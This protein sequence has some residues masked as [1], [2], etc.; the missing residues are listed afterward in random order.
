METLF[1]KR[2]CLIIATLLVGFSTHVF[3]FLDIEPKN[4][5]QKIALLLPSRGPHAE[6]A[7]TIRD[8]FLAAYYKNKDS[9]QSKVSMQVYDTGDG[10]QIDTAYERALAEGANLIVG[11][12]TKAE[13]SYIASLPSL[14][15]PVLAL[16]TIPRSNDLPSNLYQF[17][18]LPE[19]DVH[20]MV[21]QAR[22]Q[23]HGNALLIAPQNEWGK[24]MSG[25]IRYFWQ[26]RGGIIQEQVLLQ[27]SEDL[28]ASIKALLRADEKD[29]SRRNDIDVIFLVANPEL[30]RQVKSLL[31]ANFAEKLPIYATSS[32]YSGT[33]N[34]IKDQ[35]LDGVHFCD[36]PLLLDNP[37]DFKEVRQNII[38]LWPES[39]KK[40]PRYFAM[41]MDSYTIALQLSENRNLMRTSAYTGDLELDDHNRILRRL[42]C[43]K[44][45]QGIPVKDTVAD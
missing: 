27:P 11:P 41:G 13:V 1:Q 35:A 38:T 5:N 22:N 19:D 8:G 28:A 33:P 39:F 32:V 42:G 7:K 30:A 18:L 15:V 36:I 40:S 43:A 10:N 21:E 9:Q 4:N 34:P 25:A 6:A 20:A 44:F 37:S 3:A 23:G 24:R 31:A 29:Y 2:I 16:N 14:A 45:D 26:K 12:L 17:G